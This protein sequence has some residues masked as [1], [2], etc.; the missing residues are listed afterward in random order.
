MPYID[1]ESRGVID[2]SLDKLI[3]QIRDTAAY[4]GE[5]YAGYLN[6]CI[7]RVIL[8]LVNPGMRY[9]DIAMICGVLDNV[10]KEFYRRHAVPCEDCKIIENGDVE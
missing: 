9:A 3:E 6:Y 10:S 8:G 5:P 4:E 7:T 2:E 1:Q